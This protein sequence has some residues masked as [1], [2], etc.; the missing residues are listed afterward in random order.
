MRNKVC[1]TFIVP[2]W[3]KAPPIAMELIQLISS[4]DEFVP[5][6]NISDVNFTICMR[7]SNATTFNEQRRIDLNSCSCRPS[8]SGCALREA[9]AERRMALCLASVDPGAP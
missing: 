7:E 6:R 8:S 9:G 2:S 5:S 3:C 4:G 1:V